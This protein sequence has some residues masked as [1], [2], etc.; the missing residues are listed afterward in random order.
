MYTFYIKRNNTTKE[1]YTP[2]QED[3][4]TVTPGET[5]TD[6]EGNTT[7]TPDVET[8]KFKQWTTEDLAELSEKYKEL[9][10]SYTTDQIKVVE[11]LTPDILVDIAD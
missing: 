4:V 6:E 5:I 8:S 1:I 7:T 2:Y 3:I 11:E 10:A 9:L